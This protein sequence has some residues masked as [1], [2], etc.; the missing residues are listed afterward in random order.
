MVTAATIHLSLLGSEGLRRVAAQCHANTRSLVAA[1]TSLAGVELR[2]APYFH[3]AVLALPRPVAPLL[4]ELAAAGILGGYDL[5]ADFP[6][7]GQA[8]LVCATELR[9]AEDIEAY[10]LALAGALGMAVAA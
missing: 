8:L 7:L 5:S 2:F 1:L 9:T 6:E 3:E 4:A 10:R